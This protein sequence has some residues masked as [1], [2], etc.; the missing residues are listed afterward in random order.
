MSAKT[1]VVGMGNPI[2]G[3][4]G[5]GWRVADKVRAELPASDTGPVTIECLSVGGLALM[6]RLVGYSRAILVD[7]VTIGEG[8]DGDLQCVPLSALP[9]LAGGH[10]NS[11]HDS[12]LQAAL[13]LGR[14]MGFELPSEIWVVG[15]RASQV[16]EFSEQLS[17]PV[18]AAVEPATEAVLELLIDEPKVSKA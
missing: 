16:L 13:A 10:L 5:I 6:E 18:A 1:I 4:D 7:A 17:G 2:L 12:S 3:D 9:D 14:E 11:S 15:V 8:D